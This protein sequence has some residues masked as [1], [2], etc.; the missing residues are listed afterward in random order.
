MRRYRD[1]RNKAVSDNHALRKQLTTLEDSIRD[2]FAKVR[3]FDTSEHVQT[4][5]NDSSVDTEIEK[6]RNQEHDPGHQD[7]PTELSGEDREHGD[8][9]VATRSTFFY[10]TGS[11]AS[12]ASAGVSSTGEGPSEDETTSNVQFMWQPLSDIGY[13][14]I[15]L[16]A[17]FKVSEHIHCLVKAGGLYIVPCNTLIMIWL[18]AVM[19]PPVRIDYSLWDTFFMGALQLGALYL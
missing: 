5:T 13:P 2:L 9:A 19:K 8:V 15:T 12:I 6:P 7:L 4:L 16:L 17:S 3:H 14:T 1:E 10:G 18:H 11:M